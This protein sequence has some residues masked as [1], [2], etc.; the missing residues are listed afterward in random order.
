MQIR[1]DD[2]SKT[3]VYRRNM[4]ILDDP[5]MPKEAKHNANKVLRALADLQNISDYH[6]GDGPDEHDGG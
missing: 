2:I 1:P 6:E 5:Y 3:N 4:A